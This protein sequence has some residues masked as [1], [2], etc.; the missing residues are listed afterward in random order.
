MNNS[1]RL[2]KEYVKRIESFYN[3]LFCIFLVYKRIST[4]YPSSQICSECGHQD[5]SM[6]DYRKRKYVCP[7]C[8]AKIE[9]DY[10]ASRNVFQER[11]RELKI[12]S[13]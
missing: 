6:K 5:I 1:L 12:I 13:K 11:L 3:F 2:K 8:K 4:Y 9:R 7:V 10:N